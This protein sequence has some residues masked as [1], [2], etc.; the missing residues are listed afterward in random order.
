MLGVFV[1]EVQQ[2]VTDNGLIDY[3]QPCWRVFIQ[4]GKWYLE[5]FASL[6]LLDDAP[7]PNKH[8]HIPSWCPD[9]TLSYYAGARVL[10]GAGS[11][12]S[13]LT[14]IQRSKAAIEDTPGSDNISFRGFCVDQP[15]H[16]VS[17]TPDWYGPQLDHSRA[18]GPADVAEKALTWD[19]ECLQLTLK[20]CGIV[21]QDETR[22]PEE[23]WRTLVCN[24]IGRN[25]T[26]TKEY[27]LYYNIWKD[28]LEERRDNFT[29]NIHLGY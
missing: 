19:T 14:R 13:S 9:Y 26:C 1:P 11:H 28:Y 12:A 29:Q 24:A 27:V 3:S 7:S 18:T 5:A 23:Y 6:E 16:I 17:P 22:V 21:R 15:S 8:Q 20:T 4:F 25:T 10:L 2:D